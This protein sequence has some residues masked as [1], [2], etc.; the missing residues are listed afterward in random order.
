MKRIML[1]GFVGLCSLHQSQA[2]FWNSSHNPTH[3]PS[4]YGSL[5]WQQAK[6]YVEDHIADFEHALRHHVNNRSLTVLKNMI[7]DTIRENTSIYHYHPSGTYK[8]DLLDQYINSAILTYIEQESYQY[9]YK[10]IKNRKVAE[11]IS[12]SMRNNAMALMNHG[13]VDPN[14]LVKFVG[15]SLHKAVREALNRFDLPYEQQIQQPHHV[16]PSEECVV[17]TESFS[18][19]RRIF[20]HPCGH[21]MCTGCARQYFFG[22]YAKSTCPWCR[23]TVNQQQL[24]LALAQ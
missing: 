22:S 18:I 9:A 20:F 23:A 5:T 16:Y 21:D 13:A 3:H 2:F 6:N 24:K 14:K 1:L 8:K 4:S 17:C 7:L 15:K 11:K 10:K 19:V 12:E